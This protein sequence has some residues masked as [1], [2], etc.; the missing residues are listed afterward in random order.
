MLVQIIFKAKT[1]GPMTMKEAAYFVYST[2]VPETAG[3]RRLGKSHVEPLRNFP[4]LAKAAKAA[5]EGRS[6]SAADHLQGEAEDLLD[7]PG[8]RFAESLLAILWGGGLIGFSVWGFHEGEIPLFSGEHGSIILVGGGA[9]WLMLGANLVL[10]C[11]ALATLAGKV[12]AGHRTA[13]RKATGWLGGLGIATLIAAIV[14][15]IGQSRVV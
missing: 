4:E 11:A 15:G 5:A 14:L 1:H 13:F 8:R 2:L 3:V 12:S 10:A 9:R 7:T 6:L